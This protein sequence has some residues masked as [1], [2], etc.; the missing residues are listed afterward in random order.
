MENSC[1]RFSKVSSLSYLLYKVTRGLSRTCARSAD[2]PCLA[3]GVRGE[4]HIGTHKG[5]TRNTQGTYI[6]RGCSVF[7][8][9][10]A[11]ALLG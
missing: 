7:S 3:A 10:G 11:G 8:G 6:Y 9:W 1:D 5:H 4:V 2:A